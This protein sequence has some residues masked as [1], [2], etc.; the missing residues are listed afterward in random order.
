[1]HVS[2][3]SL[4]N[5]V[6]IYAEDYDWIQYYYRLKLSKEEKLE[7]L[8]PTLVRFY[9]NPFFPDIEFR[10]NGPVIGMLMEIL[11]ENGGT[12]VPHWVDT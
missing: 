9:S 3:I 1:M 6:L 5:H 2:T 11:N 8:M 10:V 12:K 4:N 7:N